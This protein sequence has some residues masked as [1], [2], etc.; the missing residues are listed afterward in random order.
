MTEA[1]VLVLGSVNADL[2]IRT[3]RLPTPGETVLGSEFFRAGGGK[4]ANQA[5][6]A[7]RCALRPVAFIAAVGDD[8]FGREA[9]EQLQR[10]NLDCRQLKVVADTPTGVALITV[11]ELGENTISVA[12]GANASLLPQDVLAIDEGTLKG[13]RVFLTCLESPVATVVAALRRARQAGLTTLLNPAPANSEILDEEILSL[14]DIITPNEGEAALL[15][16]ARVSSPEAA[17]RMAHRFRE[18]GCGEVVLTR[19]AQGAWIITEEDLHPVA[20]H[21]VE[22]VDTTA[23]GD[24][25]NGALAVA[26]SEGR[27]LVEACHWANAAAA[28]AVTRQGARPSLPTRAEIETLVNSR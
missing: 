12:S 14:V 24:A 4:G 23:A 2:I 16:A 13:A 5:V 21:Q 22:A 18:L 8:L 15:A 25:F 3:P 7:A 28:I 26:L 6:A 27:E 9:I 17:K 19:G 1:H 11:D 20:A 10:E